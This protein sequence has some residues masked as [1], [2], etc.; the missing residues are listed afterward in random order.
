MKPL[1]NE[2]LIEEIE[3][4]I[5]KNV[6]LSAYEAKDHIEPTL[7]EVKDDI[8]VV[9]VHGLKKDLVSALQAKEEEMKEKIK[10]K[11]KYWHIR[12]E[13]ISDPVISAERKK[14]NEEVS[15]L[16]NSVLDDLLS[17]LSEK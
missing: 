4:L 11:K 17:N 16:I 14:F 8:M 13:G 6:A 2:T 9:N 10:S 3:R 15:E 1:T 7:E 5:D 12:F